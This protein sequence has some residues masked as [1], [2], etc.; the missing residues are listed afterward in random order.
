MNFVGRLALH[1]SHGGTSLLHELE[2]IP[3]V[4][5]QCNSTLDSFLVKHMHYSILVS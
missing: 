4:L 5:D 3:K 1:V 2:L